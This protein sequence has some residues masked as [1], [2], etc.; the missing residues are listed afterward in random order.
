ME[1]FEASRKGPSL[2]AFLGTCASEEGWVLVRALPVMMTPAFMSGSLDGRRT[3][4]IERCCRW[5]RIID[6]SSAF[7]SLPT[8][9]PSALRNDRSSACVARERS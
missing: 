3:V 2:K 9:K 6:I 1:R 4:R 8:E 7:D 5:S